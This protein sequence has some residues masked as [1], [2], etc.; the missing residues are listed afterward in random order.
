MKKIIRLTESDLMR[1]VKRVI[2]EQGVIDGGVNNDFV[3]TK[4]N[5]LPVKPVKTNYIPGKQETDNV[6]RDIGETINLYTDMANKKML[7]HFKI[8]NVVPGEKHKKNITIN[9]QDDDSKDYKISFTCFSNNIG[10]KD[11]NGNLRAPNSNVYSTALSDNLKNGY[12]KVLISTS[13]DVNKKKIPKVIYPNPTKKDLTSYFQNKYKN[14]V[15]KLYNDTKNYIGG[16]KIIEGEVING[17]VKIV[18]ESIEPGYITDKPFKVG[19]YTINF[20]CLNKNGGF[21]V[22]EI[23]SDNRR[24]KSTVY[25]PDLEKDLNKFF[26]MTNKSGVQVPKADFASTS[27]NNSQNYTNNSQNYLS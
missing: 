25:L 14:Y 11:L 5:N 2:N 1:L 27:T 17:D 23:H 13:T 10:F 21:K 16:F 4:T 22:V 24:I 26:C 3:R 7:G 19:K 8:K 15:F 20:S 12:C 6:I 9:L 18:I